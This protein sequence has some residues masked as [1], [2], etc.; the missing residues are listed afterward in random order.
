MTLLDLGLGLY[1]AYDDGVF[2]NVLYG[3]ANDYPT[4][5]NFFQPYARHTM[6]LPP[7]GH[8][9]TRPNIRPF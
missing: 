7:R 4:V 9:H 2:D 1:E 5:Y 3:M 6:P 8:Q